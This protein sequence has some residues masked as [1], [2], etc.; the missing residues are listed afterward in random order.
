V[1]AAL[2][3]VDPRVHL[4]HVTATR[5]GGLPAPSVER[6]KTIF[7]LAGP[8]IA[9]PGCAEQGFDGLELEPV[10]L[11]LAR[12]GGRSPLRDLTAGASV[13][14]LVLAL[15]SSFD[16]ESSG[17]LRATYALHIGEH[18][19]TVRVADGRLTVVRGDS[20]KPDVVIE[21]D[22]ATFA[23][24]IMHRQRLRDATAGEQLTL[25]G[26]RDRV[27]RLLQALAPPR[28]APLP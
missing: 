21:T 13:D 14:A 11:H 4:K 18:T 5:S 24:L 9:R 17:N 28:P 26:D 1:D 12:W 2:A 10:L 22:A 23:S 19:F 27:E 8:N 3:Q 20:P 25:T 15:L 6:R 16:P 7:S